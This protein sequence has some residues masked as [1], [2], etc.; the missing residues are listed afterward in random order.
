MGNCYISG[1]IFTLM[2]C[3]SQPQIVAALREIHIDDLQR[4]EVDNVPGAG[5]TR[6]CSRRSAAGSSLTRSDTRAALARLRQLAGAGE[7]KALESLGASPKVGTTGGER[8]GHL[9]G[10][11]AVIFGRGWAGRSS[12]RRAVAEPSDLLVRAAQSFK[13]VA[14]TRR[15]APGN[16]ADGRIAAVGRTAGTGRIAGIQGPP[17]KACIRPE[18]PSR[19]SGARIQRFTARSQRTRRSPKQ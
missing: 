1:R 14:Q 3:Q 16:V 7:A 12:F 13:L 5:V 2:T 10:F 18:R 11:G 9:A 19:S 15:V 4:T 8:S 17:G 6:L